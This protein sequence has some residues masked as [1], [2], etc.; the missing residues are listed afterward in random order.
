MT[1]KEARLH[2]FLSLREA[3]KL[4]G[5]GRSS[6]SLWEHGRPPRIDQL[7]DLCQ[8]YGIDIT[9]LSLSEWR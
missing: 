4:T 8:A 7:L 9:D 2:C 5:Y 1:L 6:I 3:E